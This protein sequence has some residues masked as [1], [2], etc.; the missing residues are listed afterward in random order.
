MK[1]IDLGNRILFTDDI[2]YIYNTEK[3][4]EY[5]NYREYYIVT[6]VGKFNVDEYEYDKVKAY[7]LS[8]NEDIPKEDKKYIEHIKMQEN[9][10]HNHLNI[11]DKLNEIIDYINKDTK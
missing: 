6:K 2:Q 3:C 1:V 8:L 9:E 10:L 4:G 7:L 5:R 11:I